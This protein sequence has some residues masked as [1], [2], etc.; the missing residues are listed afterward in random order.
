MEDTEKN[1]KLQVITSG[2]D[3]IKKLPSG[4]SFNI[5][6][7]PNYNTLQVTQ[8]LFLDFYIENL[9]Q[10]NLACMLIGIK[11][12]QID[13]WLESSP[14]FKEAYETV[15]DVFTEGLETVDYLDSLG[16]SKIRGRVIDR[17][18][19]KGSNNKT[20]NNNTL[21]VFGEGGLHNL[22]QLFDRG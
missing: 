4:E 6:M 11:I 5:T 17:R 22:K 21:N 1:N 10:K 19:G 7:I 13:Q 8:Q 14:E 9:L 16:N 20:V 3:V 15:N 12:S 18:R 2:M